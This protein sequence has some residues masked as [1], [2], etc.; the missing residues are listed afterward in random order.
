MKSCVQWN[1]V[2]DKED[3][4]LCTPRSV[5]QRLTHSAIMAKTLKHAQRVYIYD[6]M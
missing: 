6:Y 1:N 4:K 3:F 5:G 2:Y